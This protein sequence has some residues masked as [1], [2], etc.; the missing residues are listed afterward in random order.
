M[1]TTM[2]EAQANKTVLQNGIQNFLRGNIQAVLDA[3]TDDIEWTT[4]EHPAVPFARSYKGKKGV[5]EFFQTLAAI[6]DFKAFEPQAYYADGNTVFARIFQHG[7][8][9]STG[10]EYK[11]VFIFECTFENENMKRTFAYVDSLD[12]ANACTR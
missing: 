12:Q 4:W 7:V 2:T 5:A 10:K 1:T 9:K 3:C 6:T 8:V 11:H